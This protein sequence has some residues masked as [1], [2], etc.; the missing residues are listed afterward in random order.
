MN[1][2]S[3]RPTDRV[4]ASGPAPGPSRSRP[5]ASVD[6]Y[7]PAHGPARRLN[8]TPS[9]PSQS[10]PQNL[11]NRQS[12][13]QPLT[14]DPA[15][16]GARP[17]STSLSSLD[18]MATPTPPQR[19]RNQA[20]PT[21]MNNMNR[22]ANNLPDVSPHSSQPSRS[23]PPRQRIGEPSQPSSDDDNDSRAP[24]RASDVD[25]HR[26]CTVQEPSVV[27][28]MW[29]EGEYIDIEL[30]GELLDEQ[31]HLWSYHNQ[32]WLLI[33]SKPLNTSPAAHNGWWFRDVA[34]SVNLIRPHLDRKGTSLLVR[35][36]V[37]LEAAL[38][39]L[40]DK[41][42]KP[43]GAPDVPPPGYKFYNRFKD[44][45]FVRKEVLACLAHIKADPNDALRRCTSPQGMLDE[46]ARNRVW[47]LPWYGVYDHLNRDTV[48]RY[49]LQRAKWIKALWHLHT[50]RYD[51]FF[52]EVRGYMVDE[53][54]FLHSWHVQEGFTNLFP[55]RAVDA[56]FIHWQDIDEAAQTRAPIYL[57]NPDYYS[58]LFING[59][60]LPCDQNKPKKRGAKEERVELWT[61]R[62]KLCVTGTMSSHH[63]ANASYTVEA[64]EPLV[65]LLQ[66]AYNWRLHSPTPEWPFNGQCVPRAFW[67]Q[68]N[69]RIDGKV[70]QKPQGTLTCA[71][72]TS[73][74][75]NPMSPDEM[76][77]RYIKYMK[78]HVSTALPE[79]AEA[80]EEEEEEEDVRGS[81]HGPLRS[82]RTRRVQ[83]V[84]PPYQLR[85]TFWL[86]PEFDLEHF[87][88]IDVVREKGEVRIRDPTL[89]AD[90]IL[91]WGCVAC[92]SCLKWSS[93]TSVSRVCRR[94]ERQRCISCRRLTGDS[95][96]S[97]QNDEFG[98][99]SIRDYD[100]E[101]SRNKDLD[102][103]DI[104]NI[105]MEKWFRGGFD[106]RPT[107]PPEVWPSVE[108]VYNR[109]VNAGA[110][111]TVTKERYSAHS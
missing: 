78:G 43:A 15:C 86:I 55:N 64:A 26:M 90:I 79:G 22:L 104:D 93:R 102:I 23:Q 54:M 21:G 58:S 109:L 73:S 41:L 24:S 65:S 6:E 39:K 87:P 88:S 66:F 111:T 16:L 14:Q 53:V 38:F 99:I 25:W 69:I 3:S 108:E 20:P 97:W 62:I 1:D 68:L 19:P 52:P 85:R 33:H 57:R 76:N 56:P 9:T 94:W 72:L 10:T 92:Y 89:P 7:D 82:R 100:V 11:L 36:I 31:R 48:S 51:V 74:E 49:L 106:F 98:N 40:A 84:A 46:L 37:H 75:G 67:E 96:C 61:K 17:H 110:N 30:E 27:W 50:N 32:L 63:D 8:I 42:P 107:P 60:L 70:V 80:E 91:A 105:I 13:V 45:S 47:P 81:E 83:D 71:R 101:G 35:F 18:P 34:A 44:D 5:R 12:P 29:A 59:I 2:K 4:L 103:D 28:D 95:W 77:K